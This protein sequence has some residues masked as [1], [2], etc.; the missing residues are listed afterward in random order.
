MLRSLV[1]IFCFALS[2][3]ALAQEGEQPPVKESREEVSIPDVIRSFAAREKAFKDAR[4][5][6]TYT[7]EVVVKAACQDGQTGAYHLIVDFAFDSKGT[8]LEKVRATDS[9]LQCIA[10]TKEDLEGFRNQFLFLLTTDDIPSYEIKFVGRQ[11]QDNL[12]FYVFDISPNTISAGQPR[13]KGR[14]WVD[15]H[16]FFIVKSQGTIDMEREKKRKG[17][18]KPFPAMTTWREQIDG[19]Y[20]F[21]AYGQSHDILHF[22]NGDV[23]VDEAIKLTNYKATANSK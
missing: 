4:E 13:F 8:R 22:S 9:T 7:Q 20:W 23:Q 5:K 19:R 18:E 11:Q 16:D 1:L 12:N 21:P 6:Y 17:Q 15:G 10:I 14:I 3:T 2:G